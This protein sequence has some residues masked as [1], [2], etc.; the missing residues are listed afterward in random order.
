MLGSSRN[1]TAT[2]QDLADHFRVFA[3]DLR[4]HGD[5]P[6]ADEAS[7]ADMAADVQHWME[8]HLDQ[9][10]VLVGHSLGGKVAMRLAADTPGKVRALVLAD[11][12]PRDYAPHFAD[13]VAALRDLDLSGFQSRADADRALAE[14]IPDFAFRRFLLTN[15][16]RDA[17]TKG[18]R[19]QCHLE[20]IAG[21]LSEWS[22]NPLRTDEQVELPTLA[23]RGR[24][25]DFVRDEDLPAF[26]GHFPNLEM[27]TLEAAHNVHFDVREEF[28]RALRED[29]SRLCTA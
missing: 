9:T 1:W 3:L 13:D 22:R 25:S 14:K 21:H 26:H 7:Y 19:W 29:R 28:V 24:L 15:L 10:P 5:S 20:A 23:I 12:A 2:A 11:I 16:T 4:N 6:H 18:F 8:Q 27:I 17:A